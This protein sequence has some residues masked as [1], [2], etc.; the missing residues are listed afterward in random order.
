MKLRISILISTKLGMRTKGEIIQYKGKK[1]E[2]KI[3]LLAKILAKSSYRSSHHFGCITKFI[4]KKLKKTL[5]V[6][7]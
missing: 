3:I 2:I 4:I 7:N 6:H 5:E 1:L